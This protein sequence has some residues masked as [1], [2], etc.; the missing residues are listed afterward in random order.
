MCVTHNPSLDP[1][2][3]GLT[4]LLGSRYQLTSCARFRLNPFLQPAF[5][6]LACPSTHLTSDHS[7]QPSSLI[8]DALSRV[9]LP[10][11]CALVV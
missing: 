9:G 2:S 8:F 6:T 11:P 1:D 4:F 3:D 10:P 5:I 7:K